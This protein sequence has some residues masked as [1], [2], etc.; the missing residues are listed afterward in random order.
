M[1]ESC[2]ICGRELCGTQRRWLFHPAAKVSL[3]VLLSHVLGQEVSRDGRAEFA[4]SKCAFMLE[5]I[6][7]YDTVVARIEALSLERLHKLLLEKERLKACLAGLYRKHNGEGGGGGEEEAA[8]AAGARGSLPDASYATLLQED[9]AYSG[10]ECWTGG[11][12]ER[13]GGGCGGDSHACHTAEGGGRPRRCRGCAALRVADADY[14]AICKIPRKVARSISCGPASARWSPSLCPEDSPPAGELLPGGKA[15]LDGESLGEEGTP[16]SSVE[17]LDPALLLAA[18]ATTSPS[19]QRDEEADSEARRSGKCDSCC[20]SHSGSL[21]GNRLDVALSLVRAFDCKPVR[22]PKGSRLPV[23]VRSSA[24]CQ[25]PG[26]RGAALEGA[27]KTPGKLPARSAFAF[28]SEMSDLQEL[29]ESLCEDYMPLQVKNSW[30]DQ[31]QLTWCDSSMGKQ[32]S[33]F[34]NAEL[35]EKIHHFDANN[36]LLQEKLNEMDFELKSAQQTSQRQDHKIQNLNETLKSKETESEELYRVIEG[37]NETITKL[38]D[39]LHRTQLGQLQVSESASS[40][41]QKQQMALLELQNTLFLTQLEAQQ[42]QRAEQQRERQLAEGKR[43]TQLLET[44]LQEEEQQKEAAWKHNWELRATLQQLQTE[45]QNKNWQCW[46]LEREKCLVIKGQEQKIKQLNYCLAYKEQLVQEFKELLQYHQNLDKSPASAAADMVQKLQQRIKDRDAALEQAVD[47]KFQVLEEKEQ[48]LQQLHWSLR[49]R[50]HDLEGLRR[51]LSDNE[52]T[53][54]GLESM[55]KAKGLEMEQLSATC[56][57]FQWLKEEVEAKSQS[58]QAEQAGIIQQLRT[59]LHERNKEVEALS[60][61]LQCKLGPGQRDIVE[62]LCFRLQQKERVIQEL[63]ND[64]NRQAEEQKAEIQ[65]LLQAMSAKQQQSCSF[66][67]KMAQALIE[68]SCE[69]QVLHQQLTGQIPGRKAEG[70]PAQLSQEGQSSK[71]LKQGRSDENVST[72]IPKGKDNTSKK[73]KGVSESTAGLEKELSSVKDELELLA[74]KERESRLELSALQ[75]VVASQEEELQVQASDVESLTRSIQIK[76]ELIK[77]LQM[78]LVDPEEMPAMERLTQEVLM[79]REKV[80]QGESQGQEVTGNRK[81]QLL[82]LLEELAAEK[83][84]LNEALQTEKQLYNTLVKFHAHPD[85]TGQEQTLQAELEGARALHKRLEEALGRT[86]ERLLRLDSLD[87]NGGGEH[88]R[89]TVLP[90]HAF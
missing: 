87:T 32:A 54:Q 83:N 36:K 19:L 5:R 59:T 46:T 23:P 72:M 34:N 81:Q 52:T 22:S 58:W 80:A 13:G 17:S 27:L 10:F 42:M 62:E 77:D 88:H 25:E 31:Q 29:W 89:V 82:L 12:E 90:K 44:W 67:E 69:L 75:S 61:A 43:A 26:D 4:C 79:L 38:Q 30:E 8:A 37:Q 3:Q 9:F 11:P 45:L 55:L 39:I 49:E 73:E 63:L 51:V 78:Q 71:A 56:Q 2:R 84:Q 15:P 70:S 24:L 74:R 16:G 47:E 60:A 14:E 33:E 41:Q 86:L 53:I 57:N 1:R 7:R 20:G 76:E 68:R 48:E 66:S 50:E 18:A 21:P 6:Y 64:K 40:S 35:L 65:S 28:P 85:S